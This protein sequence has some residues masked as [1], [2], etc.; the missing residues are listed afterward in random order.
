MAGAN[1]SGA[2]RYA[3]WSH[4]RLSMVVPIGI[5]VATAIVCVIM[6]ALSSAK[7]ADYVA[8]DNERQLFSRALVN[9]AERVLRNISAVATSEAA[10]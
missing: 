5:I 2:R 4:M 3:G 9:Q 1:I 7:R 6:A 10:Y 8:L